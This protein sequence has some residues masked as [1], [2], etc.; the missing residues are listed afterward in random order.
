MRWWGCAVVTL[1]GTGHYEIA[2]IYRRWRVQ[3]HLCDLPC[4]GLPKKN[5]ETKTKD[6]K[7]VF[8][9]T[10]SVLGDI[11]CMDLM[12]TS[13]CHFKWK[14]L[15][16][17]LGHEQTCCKGVALRGE[18]ESNT[19][20]S[21]CNGKHQHLYIITNQC[22]LQRAQTFSK[23]YG[24]H[25]CQYQFQWWFL[26]EQ[27]KILCLSA[28][29]PHISLPCEGTNISNGSYYCPKI[30]TKIEG[31]CQ[32]LSSLYLSRSQTK[33]VFSAGATIK[34]HVHIFFFKMNSN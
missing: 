19:G 32:T 29:D 9:I 3:W 10:T 22:S 6:T 26:S 16:P 11:Y 23:I 7:G 17:Q 4:Q 1:L 15:W 2:Q 12:C 28:D 21:W 33:C 18:Y 20:A 25:F 8:W 13:S 30:T 5:D 34:R 14:S 24:N 27:T 31:Q